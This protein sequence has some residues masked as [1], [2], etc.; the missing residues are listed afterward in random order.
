MLLVALCRSQ[1]AGYVTQYAK[2]LTFITVRGKL[3]Q[4]DCKLTGAAAGAGHMVP[5]WK[6]QEALSMLDTF[7][8]GAEFK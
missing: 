1:V 6:P 5:Q 7:L 8:K 4:L 2:N 3:S